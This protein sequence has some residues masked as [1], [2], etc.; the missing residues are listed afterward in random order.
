MI[1]DVTFHFEDHH[2]AKSQTS[3]QYDGGSVLADGAQF[4]AAQTATAAL[5][6]DLATLTTAR[7]THSTITAFVAS[8]D[9]GA[10]GG[11]NVTDRAALSVFVTPSNPALGAGDVV[12]A[13]GFPSPAPTLFLEN[14]GNIDVTDATLLA[15]GTKLAN[16][17]ADQRGWVIS[18]GEKPILFLGRVIKRGYLS[19][20]RRSVR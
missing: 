20:R 3:L 13:F 15:V 5:G 18:D 8:G 11:S 12:R 14:S 17:P 6:T 7:L 19:S 2:G 16:V 9:V 1:F 10:A 4:V